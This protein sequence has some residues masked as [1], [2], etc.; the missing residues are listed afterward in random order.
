[1][2][3]NVGE[4]VQLLTDEKFKQETK[5]VSAKQMGTD[6]IIQAGLQYIGAQLSAEQLAQYMWQVKMPKGDDVE[7]T[8]ETNVI[9]LPMSDAKIVGKVLPVE[10]DEEVNVYMVIRSEDVNK[11]GLRIDLIGPGTDFQVEP[12]NYVGE[13]KTWISDHLAVVEETRAEAAK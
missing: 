5:K 2:K 4:T 12:N 8:I 11:S 13:V 3:L 10:N 6:A 1:M 7:V 9:N